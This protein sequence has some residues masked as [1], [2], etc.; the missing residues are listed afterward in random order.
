MV[1]IDKCGVRGDATLCVVIFSMIL[2]FSMGHFLSFYTDF[3]RPFSKLMGLWRMAPCLPNHSLK[4]KFYCRISRIS[5]NRGLLW[6][7]WNTTSKSFGNIAD[8]GGLNSSAADYASSHIDQA[9]FTE[10]AWDNYVSRM[11]GYFVPPKTGEY[12]F[13]IKADD[14]ASLLFSATSNPNDKV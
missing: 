8:V 2:K 13:H 6:E 1:I 14:G 11:S 5:G 12:S 3:Y 4:Q 10:A 7:T 9:Y